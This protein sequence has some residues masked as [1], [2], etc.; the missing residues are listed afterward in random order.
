M[1]GF[2]QDCTLPPSSSLDLFLGVVLIVCFVVGVPANIVSFKFF[3]SKP[4]PRDLPTCIYILITLTDIVICTL[5]LVPAVSY[6][7][8][9]A[10]QLFHYSGM[11]VTWGI[12]IAVFPAFTIFTLALL[13]VTRTY[14]VQYPLKTMRRRGCLRF[15]LL[16]FIILVSDFLVVPLVISTFYV[17]F[18]VS[19]SIKTTTLF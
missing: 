9:R 19:H 6:L 5:T 16:Y 13:S 15:L 1:G 3:L 10:P 4:S 12:F 18:L 17:R 2:S 8:G 14:N 7:S 11:C